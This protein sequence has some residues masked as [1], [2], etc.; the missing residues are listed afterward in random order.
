MFVFGKTEFFTERSNCLLL[1]D[2]LWC[3]I[4]ELELFFGVDGYSASTHTFVAFVHF[5]K[6][7]H[8]CALFVKE[9]SSVAKGKC[10]KRHGV[11]DNKL[12]AFPDLNVL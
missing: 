7:T 1:P 2:L 5:S 8:K 4:Q 6:L 9:W 11:P 12:E 10:L 3:P